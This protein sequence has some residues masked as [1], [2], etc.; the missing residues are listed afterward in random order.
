METALILLTLFGCNDAGLD[1]ET[2]ARSQARFGTM[3]AC[4]AAI[5]PA[6][7]GVIGLPFPMVIAQCGTRAETAAAIAA[8]TR[9]APS[10]QNDNPVEMAADSAI[11]DG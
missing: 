11:A 1:C 2:L 7:D 5:D 6:F 10:G 3:A 4:E 8:L 9:P